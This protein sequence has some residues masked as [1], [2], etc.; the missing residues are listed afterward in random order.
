MWRA[1]AGD[2]LKEIIKTKTVVDSSKAGNVC[3]ERA[4]HVPPA[5]LFWPGSNLPTT[6]TA[7]LPS[8]RPSPP[9]PTLR[10]PP[11][12]LPP[13]PPS[14]SPAQLLRR[15]PRFPD[16][17]RKLGCLLSYMWGSL[18]RLLSCW[19]CILSY[20]FPWLNIYFD[21]NYAFDMEI[22]IEMVEAWFVLFSFLLE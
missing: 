20:F 15:M 18:I 14:H 10:P 21:V 13:P 22:E 8:P 7:L 19:Y 12:L 16:T 3:A 17:P 2:K 6:A 9:C 5:R 1:N 4:S 11:P